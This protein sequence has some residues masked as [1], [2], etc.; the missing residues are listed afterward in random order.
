MELVVPSLL[1]PFPRHT[2]LDLLHN[3]ERV[4]I[5]EE[6]PLGPGSDP[7]SGRGALRR[8]IRGRVRRLA[9]PPVPIP[10]ARSLEV[11]ESA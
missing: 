5:V 7:S 2:L 10:A 3:R 9:P 11:L 4:A 6:S 8:R 1:Q